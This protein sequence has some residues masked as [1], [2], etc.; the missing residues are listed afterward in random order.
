MAEQTVDVVVTDM[1]MPNMSGAA[2]L[3]EVR[4]RYP[5]TVRIVL[6]GQSDPYLN[7]DTVAAQHVLSKPCD[8]PTLKATIEQ[9]LD[10]MGR[11]NAS[12][13]CE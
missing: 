7:L 6:S 10:P 11:Q 13:N 8:G 4:R 5:D 1:R 2:L 12:L 9:A 3:N